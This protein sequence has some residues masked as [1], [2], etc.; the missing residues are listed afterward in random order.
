MSAV[1]AHRDTL[2]E[3]AGQAIDHGLAEGVPPAI[4]PGRYPEPLRDERAAF[5]TLFDGTG[6]LRGCIGSIEAHRPLVADVAENAFAAAFR[7][8][9]FPPLVPA[10]RADLVCK[11]SVLTPAEPIAFTDESDLL[12]RIEPGVDGL[13]LEAG[14]HRG[15][16]LP[17]VWEQLP[18]PVDFWHTLKRKAGL[19]ADAFPAGLA[20][21]RYRAEEVG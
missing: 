21:Y 1:Q 12:G 19:D 20:V 8:P 6:R 13:L 7:D 2:L 5:V 17:A 14:E 18:D 4:D 9:R 3:L 16:L 10:E 11:L 15:T